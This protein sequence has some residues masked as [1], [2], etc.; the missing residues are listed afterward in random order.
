MY[1]HEDSPSS[2]VIDVGR[3]EPMQDSSR[4]MHLPCR[5]TAGHVHRCTLEYIDQFPPYGGS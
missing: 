5:Y 3:L 2:N 4:K 1:R